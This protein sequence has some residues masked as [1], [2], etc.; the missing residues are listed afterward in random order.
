MIQFRLY[1]L[2]M[3]TLIFSIRMCVYAFCTLIGAEFL[4][5]MGISPLKKWGCYYL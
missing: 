1:L 4:S 2:L 5:E 3:Q